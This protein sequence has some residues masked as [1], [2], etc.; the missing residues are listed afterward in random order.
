MPQNNIIR[1]KQR[2]KSSGHKRGISGAG[3]SG[4]DL[5]LN[6]GACFLHLY[7]LHNTKKSVKGEER[8]RKFLFLVPTPRHTS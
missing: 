6:H 7:G 3:I 4:P 8:C 1:L 2:I 5:R